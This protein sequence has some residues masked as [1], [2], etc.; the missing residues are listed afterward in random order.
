MRYYYYVSMTTVLNLCQ[1]VHAHFG[2]FKIRDANM[3]FHS[4]SKHP[5]YLDIHKALTECLIEW[6][7]ST[8]LEKRYVCSSTVCN[9]N[10]YKI[11]VF[12]SK[13]RKLEHEIVS[14]ISR[15][16]DCMI[17]VLAN[18]ILGQDGLV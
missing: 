18:R 15:S 16:T 9:D 14:L 12:K 3:L 6:L 10:Q 1:S 17:H 13:G 11:V 4:P 7:H 2:L 5:P 8:L